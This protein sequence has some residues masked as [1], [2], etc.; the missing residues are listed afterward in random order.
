MELVLLLVRAVVGT[1]FVIHGAQ[2]LWGWFRGQGPDE[3]AASFARV[4]FAHSRALARAVGVVEAAA[5]LALTAG[6]LTPLPSMA[7]VALMIN[8]ILAAHLA[9]SR[10]WV[11]RC[12]F[13]YPGGLAAAA[14]L[15]A[16]LGPGGYAVDGAL[17]FQLWGPRAGALVAVAGP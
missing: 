1:L 16:F 10:L 11:R 8:A 12:G 15:I 6:L 5:G 13:E 14:L 17:G 4:D 3:A 9:R 7:I 2:K